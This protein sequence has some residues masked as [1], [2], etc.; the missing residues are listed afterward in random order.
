MCMKIIQKKKQELD[1][2]VSTL[3]E[4][5][6]GDENIKRNFR[7]ICDIILCMEFYAFIIV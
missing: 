3:V 1:T 7:F 2:E 4:G 5:H 6:D